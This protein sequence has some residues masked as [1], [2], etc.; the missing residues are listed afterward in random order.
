LSEVTFNFEE[1]SDRDLL[2]LS[3]S[4]QQDMKDDIVEIKDEMRRQNGRIRKLEKFRWIVV[5]LLS[6][7]GLGG[8][9]VVDHNF[10]HLLF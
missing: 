4:N 7:G 2:I 9:G 8:L 10:L 5:G 3:V 1:M 6:S